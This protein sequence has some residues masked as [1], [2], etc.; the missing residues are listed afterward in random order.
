[1]I[2]AG[3]CQQKGIWLNKIPNDETLPSEPNKVIFIIAY[4][5]NLRRKNDAKRY[6]MAFIYAY[7]SGLDI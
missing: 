3:C 1:M 7:P 6:I 2:A 4:F 5:K